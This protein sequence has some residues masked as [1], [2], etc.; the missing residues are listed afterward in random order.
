M[1]RVSTNIRDVA[2]AKRGQIIQHVLVDGWSPAQV[3]AVYDV[4]ERQVTRWVAAYRRHGMASLRGDGAAEHRPRRWI[5][6][7]RSLAA[8]MSAALYGE[9][10]AQPARCIVLRHGKDER[11]PRRVPTG[12]R[13]GTESLTAP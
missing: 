11:G 3:A 12:A 7:L 8:R 9:V 13:S 10:D 2:A 6:R 4:S 1:S 5:W